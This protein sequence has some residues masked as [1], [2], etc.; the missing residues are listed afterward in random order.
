MAHSREVRHRDRNLGRRREVEELPSVH[1]VFRM[2]DAQRQQVA[3][4]LRYIDEARRA[5]EFQQNTD[6]REIIR[7]LR[8]SADHIFDVLNALEETD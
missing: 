6:N 1:R 2:T 7:E 5:L 4:Y 3:K 8:S